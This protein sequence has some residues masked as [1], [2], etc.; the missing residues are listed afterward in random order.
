MYHHEDTTLKP[1]AFNSLYKGRAR[2]Q[3][4]SV[5][6]I[7][8]THCVSLGSRSGLIHLSPKSNILYSR[9]NL[10]L[11]VLRDVSTHSLKYFI[12]AFDF[13]VFSTL[14]EEEKVENG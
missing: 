4:G 9:S 8:A 5:T 1:D 2:S 3:S 7:K 6:Q 14:K 11:K 10:T 12:F 13:F